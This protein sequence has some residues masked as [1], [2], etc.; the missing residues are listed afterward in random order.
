MR[1]A[2]AI[3]LLLSGCAYLLPA[4]WR[5]FRADP[6]DAPPAI[7]RAID[8]TGMN[9]DSFHQGL[10]KIVTGWA[11]KSSGVT[12]IRERFTVEWERNETEGTLTVYVRHEAQE[13][14]MGEDQNA[15]GMTYHESKR[16]EHL[17]EL[18]S[19]EM[20]KSSDDF[21]PSSSD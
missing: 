10:R 2:L 17:L 16:E 14:E 18:I 4:S 13:Q 5:S 7:T 8:A 19:K 3:A 9:V 15:W 21:Q 6:D 1:A 12:R 20:A 11:T